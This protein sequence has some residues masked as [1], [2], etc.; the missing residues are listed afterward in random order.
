MDRNTALEP[1][2]HTSIHKIEK[3]ALAK[4]PKDNPKINHRYKFLSA[5]ASQVNVWDYQSDPP[6]KFTIAF[7]NNDLSLVS[8]CPKTHEIVTV[9][10]QLLSIFDSSSGDLIRNSNLSETPTCI[11]VQENTI[12]L[13][14]NQSGK[15][16]VYG[17]RNLNLMHT[18]LSDAK[19]P[20]PMHSLQADENK[21][22]SCGADSAITVFDINSGKKLYHL[23]SGSLVHRST[24]IVN[25]TKPGISQLQFDDSRIVGVIGNMMRIWS[26]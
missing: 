13:G 10:S 23:L 8:W 12:V 4:D 5:S 14:S 7:A 1:I 2:I 15:I 21:V 17:R 16:Y 22:C 3:K 9:S 6:C 18:L 20:Q 25:P 11:D 24:N 26:F 19:A